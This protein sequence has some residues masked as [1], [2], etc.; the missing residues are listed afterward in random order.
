MSYSSAVTGSITFHPPLQHAELRDDWQPADYLRLV[1]TQET[2]ETDAGALTTRSCAEVVPRLET[3][4]H[5]ESG[6]IDA[7]QATITHHSLV[8][9]QF[10]GWFDLVGED[11][12]RKRIWVESNGGKRPVRVAEA[13]YVWDEGV[14]QDT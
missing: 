6:I 7:L 12:R 1:V 2:V 8:G 3:M 4:N 10:S 13:R 9:R 5:A 11:G 14:P